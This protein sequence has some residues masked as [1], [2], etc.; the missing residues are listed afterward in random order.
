[1]TK[2]KQ[3]INFFSSTSKRGLYKYLIDPTSKHAGSKLSKKVDVNYIYKKA[4]SIK[5]LIFLLKFI[6]SGSLFNEKKCT[7]LKYENINI[8]LHA[9]S[10]AYRVSS[11]HYSKFFY[12]INLLKYLF[13]AGSM[14]N[15]AKKISDKVDAVYIDHPIYLNSVY[16]NYFAAKKKIVYSNQYPRGIFYV[17]YR[18]Q[19]NSKI[20]KAPEALTLSKNIKI[21]DYK[22]IP[23]KKIYKFFK[24]PEN[25]PWCKS[26]SFSSKI[27]INES[28]RNADYII[29]AHSFSDG[30][31]SYGYDGFINLENW[32][33]FTIDELL[34]NNSN[35]IVKGHP[36]FYND[37][38]G[39]TAVADKFVFERIFKKYKDKGIVFLNDSFKNYDVLKEVKK[40]TTLITHHGTVAIEAALFNFKCI[41]STAAFWDKTFQIANQWSSRDEYEKILKK[42][43][44]YLR[45]ANK[46]DLSIFTS[47]LFSD[48]SNFG[49]KFWHVH[50]EKKIK[51]FNNLRLHHH[52]TNQI[53]NEK[54]N[55]LIINKIKNNIVEVKYKKNGY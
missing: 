13:I 55:N 28:I 54:Q 44:K 9:V 34:K 7:S 32:M 41:C 6:L 4:P 29:Y 47:Q 26:T 23:L 5:F 21:E 35:F 52:H 50:F 48:T 36:N 12:Y 42:K 30:N 37:H 31:I 24:N 10:M 38:F 15:S 22:K 53:V 20:S 1:M 16:Y 40:T 49:K 43:W 2:R 51:N 17:D 25:I 8:G 45:Y 46:K 19:A 33:T 27:K 3:F 11:S 39:E 18:I 14:L